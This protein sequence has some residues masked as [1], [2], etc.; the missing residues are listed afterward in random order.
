MG[1]QAEQAERPFGDVLVD[2]VRASSE[3]ANHSETPESAAN[4]VRK[5]LRRI[6]EWLDE[7][8]YEFPTELDV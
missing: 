7:E 1:E 5:A 6:R 3:Y 2:Y 8:E 4:V